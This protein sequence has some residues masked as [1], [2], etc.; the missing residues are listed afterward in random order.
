[1]IQSNSFCNCEIAS[2]YV[3]SNLIKLKVV[4]S[5]PKLKNSFEI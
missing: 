3:I 2:T 1:M 4:V 5:Y